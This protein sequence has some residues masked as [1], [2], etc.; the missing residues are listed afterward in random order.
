MANPIDIAV[1]K[2]KGM[3]RSMEAR[4]D[5]LVGVFQTIARQHG[6]VA[7]LMD[8]VK[9]DARKREALWPRIKIS[10]LSHEKSELKVVYPVLDR[11]G[12]LE[13]FV[14]EHAEEAQQLEDMITRLDAMPA[15]G[16]DWMTLFE[17]LAEAVLSHANEEESEIFPAAINVIGQDRAKALD[18]KFRAT[19]K[20]FKAA[21]EKVT[22]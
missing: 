6:E 17:A 16:E 15:Q 18:D 14:A 13:H 20:D 2:A 11:Y 19:F 21:F 8:R 9:N 5:G 12:E 4:R 3:E 7:S 22:H 1:S 10:L